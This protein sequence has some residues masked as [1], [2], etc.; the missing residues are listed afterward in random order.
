EGGHTRPF[1]AR[2]VREEGQ[3]LHRTVP[4]K[5]IREVGPHPAYRRARRSVARQVRAGEGGEAT[6]PEER[7]DAREVV[8][9]DVD[10]PRPV[11]LRVDLEAIRG[12]E[13][14]ASLDQLQER[15][16]HSPEDG[17]RG[18]RRNRAK[19]PRLQAT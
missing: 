17:R 2:H 16:V 7:G 6:A 5:E 11:H 12:A 4:R 3:A 15:G 10:E 19:E 13:G 14:A 1:E 9:Q 18:G 8:V